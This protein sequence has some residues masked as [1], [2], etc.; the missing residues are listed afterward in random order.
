MCVW[1]G[2]GGICFDFNF[3]LWGVFLNYYNYFLR[4]EF[5]IYHFPSNNPNGSKLNDD[6]IKSSGIFFFLY[7][8]Y[9]VSKNRNKDTKSFI[10]DFF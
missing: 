6:A 8:F 10:G 7:S 5:K 4:V 2:G 3:F 9:T 1:G